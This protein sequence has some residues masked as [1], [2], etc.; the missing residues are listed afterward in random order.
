MRKK[1]NIDHLT[2]GVCYYPEHWDKSMWR[3][4]LKRM[5]DMGVEVIRIAEFAWNKFEPYEGQFNFEFFDEFMDMTVEEGMKVNFPDLAPFAE[6]TKSVIEEN[7]L[8]ISED[9]LTALAALSEEAAA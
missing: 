4:D 2:L 9:L 3:D 7:A 8:G 6:A 5:R 1:L